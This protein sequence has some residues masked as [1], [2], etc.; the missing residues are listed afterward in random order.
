[1]TATDPQ[2]LADAEQ[3]GRQAA[4]NERPISANPFSQAQGSPTRV[5]ALAFRRGYRQGE[6][7]QG[8]ADGDLFRG[9]A[10]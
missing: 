2:A 4:R 8:D 3:L 9:T 10:R 7:E 1:M 5:L 6:L